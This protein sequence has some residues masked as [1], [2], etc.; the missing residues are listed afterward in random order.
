VG[1]EP[2][3]NC[4]CRVSPPKSTYRGLKI[5]LKGRK[6][7]SQTSEERRLTETRYKKRS[8][9][10]RTPCR[11]H[12]KSSRQVG[13]LG[14]SLAK[15]IEERDLLQT[16]AVEGKNQE[17]RRFPLGRLNHPPPYKTALAPRG[18][19]IYMTFHDGKS[20]QGRAYSE[21]EEEDLIERKESRSNL[22]G[23]TGTS[24]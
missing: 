21:G 7:R 11:L 4:G 14:G 1:G 2:Q 23:K 15:E 9:N 19:S 16:P 22:M 13:S 5:T 8:P 24:K 10:Q 20:E 3:V 18:I 6:R 12:S 17:H